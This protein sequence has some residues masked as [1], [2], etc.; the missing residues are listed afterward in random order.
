MDKADTRGGVD[1]RPIVLHEVGIVDDHVM[2]ALVE[3]QSGN[4]IE[5]EA[6]AVPREPACD[7]ARR[8]VGETRSTLCV[9]VRHEL[10][11]ALRDIP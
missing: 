1:A 5:T 9:A 8:A 10:H 7:A 3:Y 11:D 2:S 6:A 4:T